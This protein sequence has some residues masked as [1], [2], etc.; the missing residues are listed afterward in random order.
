MFPPRVSATE[1]SDRPMVMELNPSFSAATSVVDN[2]NVP[3]PAAIPTVVVAAFGCNVIEPVPII[4]LALGPKTMS[5]PENSMLPPVPAVAAVTVKVP[6]V[7]LSVMPPLLVVALVT[8]NPPAV[9]LISMLPAPLTLAEVSVVIV[10]SRS[11]PVTVVAVRL[12]ESTLAVAALPSVILPVRAVSVTALPVSVSVKLLAI[13]PPTSV[14][15]SLKLTTSATVTA[16]VPSAERPRM[17]PLKPSLIAASS[18]VEKCSVPAP[19]S[20]LPTC[21]ACEV[22]SG[23]SVSVPVPTIEFAAPV[24]SISSAV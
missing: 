14:R 3:A 15:L 24:R 1:L 17:I 4:L 13:E 5:S 21:M 7:A 19:G 22:V 11:T 18:V 12:V 2:A 10:V 9:S 8:V 16:P 6:P 20:V 23:R